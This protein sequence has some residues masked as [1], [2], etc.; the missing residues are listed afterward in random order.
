MF[1]R[2]IKKT[3]Y[4]NAGDEHLSRMIIIAIAFVGIG[5][6][7]AAVVSA[8]NSGYPQGVQNNIIDILN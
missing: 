2:E 1:F 8:I 4:N 3:V 5:I 7:I 6:I